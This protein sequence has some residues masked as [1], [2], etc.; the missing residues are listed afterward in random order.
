MEAQWF[1]TFEDFK[2][3][4]LDTFEN[5]LTEQQIDEVREE[6]NRYK[7]ELNKRKNDQISLA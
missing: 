1:E 4:V 6:F 7:D 2:D 3:A 5:K